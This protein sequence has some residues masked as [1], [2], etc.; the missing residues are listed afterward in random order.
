MLVAGILLFLCALG[1][2]IFLLRLR[3]AK[4]G[5]SARGLE[6]KS[7]FQPSTH[8]QKLPLRWRDDP[9]IQVVHGGAPLISK[10]THQHKI[11]AGLSTK[12]IDDHDAR[13]HLIN[14]HSFNGTTPVTSPSPNSRTSFNQLAPLS[15]PNSQNQQLLSMPDPLPAKRDS[16]DSTFSDRSVSIYSQP[17][18]MLSRG[19]SVASKLTRSKT[20]RATESIP[21]VPNLPSYLKNPTTEF[22]TTMPAQLPVDDDAFIFRSTLSHDRSDSNDGL[23]RQSTLVISN[24]LKT[25][26][27]RSQSPESSPPSSPVSQIERSDSIKPPMEPPVKEPYGRRVRRLRQELSDTLMQE[28]NEKEPSWEVPLR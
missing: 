28:A 21:P 23:E 7:G 27:K 17:S 8:D 25:R 26:N 10:Q 5:R 11:Y 13:E 24:L 4:R 9:E 19:P 12:D 22:S 6:D 20:H 2:G 1:L 18:A 16:V 3:R 15:I 14:H